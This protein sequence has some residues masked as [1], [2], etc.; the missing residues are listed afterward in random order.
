MWTPRTGQN[1]P[2][3]AA[4]IARPDHLEANQDSRPVPDTKRTPGTRVFENAIKFTS[5]FRQ[6]NQAARHAAQALE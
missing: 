3:I 1:E 5:P 6:V 2:R 4:E